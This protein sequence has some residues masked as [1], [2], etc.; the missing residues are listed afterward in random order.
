MQS[1]KLLCNRE[2]PGSGN[3]FMHNKNVASKKVKLKLQGPRKEGGVLIL[4]SRR[5]G[6]R[7][8]ASPQI[9]YAGNIH[10][11]ASS[12]KALLNTTKSRQNSTPFWACQ[13]F[14]IFNGVKGQVLSNCNLQFQFQCLKPVSQSRSRQAEGTTPRCTSSSFAA[15]AS[16]KAALDV[17]ALVTCEASQPRNTHYIGLISFI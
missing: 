12:A 1:K 15:K 6:W 3:N 2:W 16:A 11:F 10:T 5:G 8:T 17:G 7:N 14:H 13:G 9:S 4:R